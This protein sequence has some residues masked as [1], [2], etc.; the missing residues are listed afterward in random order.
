VHL[1]VVV[2]CVCVVGARAGV[3]ELEEC[4]AVLP[5]TPWLDWC[6][7]VC[8]VVCLCFCLEC[9]AWAMAAYMRSS[10]PFDGIYCAS[11]A[12]GCHAAWS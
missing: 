8:M 6:L 3:L 10:L 7:F 4:C 9:R 5:S 2:Y 11:P 12:V 1:L